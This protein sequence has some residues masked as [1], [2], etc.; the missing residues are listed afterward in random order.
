MFLVRNGRVKFLAAAAFALLFA[1][2]ASAQDAAAPSQQESQNSQ[3]AFRSRIFEVKHRNP[4]TLYNVL[5]VLGS[6]VS[7]TAITTNR[8]LRTVAV[9][10]F[11]ENIA[12]IE[13]AIRRLDI[14]EPLRPDIELRVYILIASNTEGAGAPLPPELSDVVRQ[15]QST[16]FHKNYSLMS[17][18][19]MRAKDG[20][21][22]LNNKGVAELKLAVPSAPSETPIFYNYDVNSISV[23]DAGAATPKV[24]IG[25]FAFTIRVPLSLGGQEVRFEN[26]GFN[27]P[28]SLRN[29]ER[30][31][32]GT[33]SMQEKSVVVVLAANVAK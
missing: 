10:D 15:L 16:L 9:R 30:V 6:G 3:S 4:E 14:P 32:A 18:Q 1:T 21:Q 19:L 7:G 22:G 26:V 25:N 5:Q 33:T 12:V 28:V 20:R 23:E 31:V 24:Q 8:E 17:S 13:A 27:A 11:P 2:G 29:G